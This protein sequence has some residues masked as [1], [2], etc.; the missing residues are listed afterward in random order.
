MRLF[1]AVLPPRSAMDELSGRVDALRSLPD[2]GRL[3][4]AGH[5]SWHFT[6]AFYGEVADEVIPQLHARLARA[7]HRH[8]PYGLRIFGGGRFADR[9]LWAGAD[10]ELAA[11]RKLAGSA[12]AAGRRAGLTMDERPG[13]T[14]HLTLARNRTPGLSLAPFAAALDTFAGTPWTVRSLALVRSHPPIPG[15]AGK[16]PHYETVMTWPLGGHTP[17]GPGR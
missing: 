3:R 11:M 17:G 1:A 6:L 16:Q 7:A 9:V 12:S 4:W 5:D 2:A 14:P 8:A 15:V 13:Y 10:G